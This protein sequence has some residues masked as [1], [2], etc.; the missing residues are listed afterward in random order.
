MQ[1]IN[2]SQ[3][4]AFHAILRKMGMHEDKEYKQN[5]VIDYSKGRATSSKDLYYQE[6]KMLI[7]DL[8]RAMGKTDD[9]I[10]A[11]NMRK[12]IIAITRSAGWEKDGNADIDRINNFCRSRGYIKKGFNQYTYNELPKLVTQFEKVCK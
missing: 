12:K 11:D 5:L 6:A 2:K 8:N 1:F 7:D 9:E 3:L 10:R 4:G